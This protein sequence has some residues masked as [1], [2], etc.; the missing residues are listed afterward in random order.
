VPSIVTDQGNLHYEVVGSGPPVILLH[1][2]TQAWNTWRETIETFH[3]QYRMYAP[4]LWGF[5]LSDKDRRES[6]EVQDFVALIPQ[7]MDALGIVEMPIMGHSMGGTTA[8]GVALEHPE[9]VSKVAV[10]GSPVDGRSLSLFLKLAGRRFVA[11]L[12]LSGEDSPLLRTFLRLWSPF[13]SRANPQHFYDMTL[14]NAPGFNI[15]SFFT[16]I[17]S[18]RR[19]DYT[20]GLSSL[21]MPVMAIYGTQDVV[22]SPRQLRLF[23]K[24]VPHA[25]TVPVAGAGHFVMWDKPGVFNVA[26]RHF[27]E[28]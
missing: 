19:T 9:R 20:A 25:Q 2:W 18:L 3:D 16:S 11:R 13:V 23:Q 10:V 15:D 7:F 5:G 12:M 17:D 27:M 21:K 8:L 26:F 28:M 6:F 22:V 4:D 1:G 14:E 24:Y